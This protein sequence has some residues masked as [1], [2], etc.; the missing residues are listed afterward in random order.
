M[1]DEPIDRDSEEWARRYEAILD[2]VE[3]KVLNGP[4]WYGISIFPSDDEENPSPPYVYTVGMKE[5]EMPELV[6]CSV[7]Q[8]IGHGIIASTINRMRE[9][10]VRWE[11]VPQNGL[12][13]KGVLQGDF[14]VML[15]QVDGPRS[16]DVGVAFTVA[17]EFEHRRG[18]DPFPME[19]LQIVLPDP[20]GFFPE[21]ESYDWDDQVRLYD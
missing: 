3:D 11:D 18:R 16:K 10:G 2:E 14:E 12:R 9:T 13:L 7:D 5:N 21:D 15:R 6:I 17:Y 8:E 19:V 4:G 20:K 1:S